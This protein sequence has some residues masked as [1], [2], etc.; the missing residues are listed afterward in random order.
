MTWLEAV[1]LGIIQGLTEFLPISSSGHLVLAQY[2]MEIHERG[3]FL[4]V[5]LHMGTLAAI[6]IYYWSDLQNLIKD[7]FHGI[8]EAKTYIIYLGVATVPAVCS[9]LL[10]DE[11]IESTFIPSVVIA[12]FFITGLVVAATYF[13]MSHPIRQLNLKIVFYIGIAQACA[14]MPGIS[15]SGITISIALLR[16]NFSREPVKTNVFPPRGVDSERVGGFSSVTPL[17]RQRSTIALFDS[18]EKKE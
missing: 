10:L 11:F 9:G 5:I 18:P 8:A 12:M 3:V 2:F 6:L 1:I 15:R 7:A 16:V 17:A 4:E 13:S 14:L